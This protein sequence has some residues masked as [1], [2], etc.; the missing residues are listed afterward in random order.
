MERRGLC[1]PTGLCK[2]GELAG[3]NPRRD[4]TLSQKFEK[5][6]SPSNLFANGPTFHSLVDS[7]ATRVPD[8]QTTTDSTSR[9]GPKTTE[10]AYRA[11]MR[12]VCVQVMV[13]SIE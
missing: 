5:I 12:E 11:H 9:H 7:C 4:I 1:S 6:R 10:L 2:E 3:H 13:C 8:T